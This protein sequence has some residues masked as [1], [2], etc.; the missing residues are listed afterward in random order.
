MDDNT[1]YAPVDPIKAGVKGR[2][3]RCGNGNLFE[4]FL[5]VKPAC[6]VCGLDNAFAD[7]G[8]G[9]AVF[10]MLIVGFLIVGLALW[11]D[12]SFTPPVWVHAI[13]WLPL[14]V[15]VSLVLLRCLKG[16]MIALQYSNDASEGKLDR[17]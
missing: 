6:S 16:V 10:V 2:C 11:L 12:A 9:P 15:I 5:K 4:G 13:I 17:D 1:P 14:T 7:A 3:P 8:D